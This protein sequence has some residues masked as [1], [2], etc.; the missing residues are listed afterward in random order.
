MRC[1]L[2]LLFCLFLLYA[3]FFLAVFFSLF[4]GCSRG[5]KKLHETRPTHYENINLR[6]PKI[7]FNFQLRTRPEKPEMEEEDEDEDEE[8]EDGTQRVAKG[9]LTHCERRLLSPKSPKVL[10]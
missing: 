8:D 9:K 4:S 1:L 2:L 7:K 5:I 3:C 6:M 10:N